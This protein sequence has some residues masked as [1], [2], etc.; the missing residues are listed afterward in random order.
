MKI[1]KYYIFVV[2][3]ISVVFL[4]VLLTLN[5]K[6]RFATQN[7]KQNGTETI[8]FSDNGVKKIDDHLFINSTLRG[9][10]F[11]K[12]EFTSKQIVIDN[13][14]VIQKVSELL[15]NV[16]SSQ[17]K[18][19]RELAKSVCG[20]VAYY[21]KTERVLEINNLTIPKP[22]SD[23]TTGDEIYSMDA[24]LFELGVNI[25]KNEI[26]N[27]RAMDGEAQTIGTLKDF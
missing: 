8:G 20:V 1:K 4:G 23:K 21:P 5:A 24:T 2:C 16:D 17:N 11:C 19:L 3:G 9:V 25:T 26:Y 27:Y 18:N 15:K 6:Y 7:K 14:D 22:H 12:T 13:V 10:T